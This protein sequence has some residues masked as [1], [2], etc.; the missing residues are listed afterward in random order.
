[1][2]GAR[3]LN[4]QLS[5]DRRHF[6]HGSAL[7]MAGKFVA[8]KGQRFEDLLREACANVLRQI[9]KESLAQHGFDELIGVPVLPGRSVPSSRFRSSF[10]HG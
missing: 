2:E 8:K 1:M 5:I 9:I 10:P 3:Q 6:D 7:S 4:R